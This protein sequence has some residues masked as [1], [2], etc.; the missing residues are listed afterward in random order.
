MMTNFVFSLFVLI[1]WKAIAS[2]DVEEDPTNDRDKNTNNDGG[3]QPIVIVIII[4]LAI[5]VFFG[6]FLIF[7]FCISESILRFDNN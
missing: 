4:V 7:W 2:Q 1:N 5:L 6:G 3:L